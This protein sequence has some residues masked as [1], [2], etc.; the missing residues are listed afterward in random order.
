MEDNQGWSK[1]PK[2]VENRADCGRRGRGYLGLVF[3]WQ[4]QQ[5]FDQKEA[6]LKFRKSEGSV[7]EEEKSDFR[8]IHQ[9]LL[10]Q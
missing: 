7:I 2:R 8:R 5:N 1:S 4:G 10:P 3:E 9:N 6:K